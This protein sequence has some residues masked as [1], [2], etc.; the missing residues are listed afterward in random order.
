MIEL[1]LN[2]GESAAWGA[3]G[4]HAQQA[5]EKCLKVL[6]V[7]VGVHPP[8]IHTMRVLVAEVH[9]AGYAFPAFA[10]EC[11]LL[12]PYAVTIRYPE[13]APLPSE[14]EGRLMIAAARRI[15]DAAEPLIAR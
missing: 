6:L 12:D 1:N 10:G 3:A 11:E 2:A 13:Q 7:Q 15:I 14:A 8:R 5:A 4:F 9:S